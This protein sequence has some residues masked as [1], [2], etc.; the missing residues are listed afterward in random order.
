MLASILCCFSFNFSNIIALLLFF[1]MLFFQLSPPTLLPYRSIF[2]F[3]YCDHLLL[4]HVLYLF[5]LYYLCL[6][7]PLSQAGKLLCLSSIVI[8]PWLWVWKG[9]QASRGLIIRAKNQEGCAHTDTPTNPSENTARTQL[10][11]A[12]ECT[13]SI[14]YGLVFFYFQNHKEVWNPFLCQFTHFQKSVFC[15]P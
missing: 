15:F 4:S 11:I 10:S 8:T 7:A 12:T 5:T 3:S 6:P 13:Y 14:A 9:I 2:D 1:K